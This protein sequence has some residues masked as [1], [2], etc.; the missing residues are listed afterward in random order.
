MHSHIKDCIKFNHNI[1]MAEPLCRTSYFLTTNSDETG[2]KKYNFDI[3]KKNI[4]ANTIFSKDQIDHF[5]ICVEFFENCDVPLDKLRSIHIIGSEFDSGKHFVEI[6]NLAYND[7]TAQEN[8][9]I[10][11]IYKPELLK[12]QYQK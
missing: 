7:N 3:A 5:I 4:S 8:T 9:A 11:V 1:S 6:D 12:L 10:D 2:S